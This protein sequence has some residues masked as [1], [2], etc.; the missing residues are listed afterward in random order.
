MAKVKKK[1]VKKKLVRV[2][3]KIKPSSDLS[4]H[5]EVI[6]DDVPSD[7]EDSADDPL[8]DIY[9]GTKRKKKLTQ[10]QEWERYSWVSVHIHLCLL[11]K[12]CADDFMAADGVIVRKL[13]TE[14][15]QP[16]LVAGRTD[17]QLSKQLQTYRKQ[18][19]M[20]AVLNK[21]MARKGQPK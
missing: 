13:L 5:Y 4:R 16:Q 11:R 14:M 18:S 15:N 7:D 6:D 3:K 17:E 10:V 12:K 2:K 9:K 21:N 1:V 20:P 8:I 19:W